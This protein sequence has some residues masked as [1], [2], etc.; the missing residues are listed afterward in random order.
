MKKIICYLIPLL[1]ALYSCG[2]GGGGSTS[3]ADGVKVMSA[4]VTEKGSIETVGDVDWYRFRV[5]EVRSI[6]QV[7]LAGQYLAS[8]SDDDF[9]FLVSIY[10]EDAN[11][12]KTCL[13]YTS[14]SPR[15]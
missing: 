11:G 8:R 6:V 2:G 4:G 14:P 1:L 13:L 5:N 15:D 10:E 9:G 3:G 12:I 7:R